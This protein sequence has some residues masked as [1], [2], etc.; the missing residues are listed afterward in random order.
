MLARAILLTVATPLLAQ[1][2]GKDSKPPT[3]PA[4]RIDDTYA[5]YSAVLANL[6]L[7]HSDHNKKYLIVDLTS[8]R[9]ENAAA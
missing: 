1:T 8:D 5:V 2:V 7:S 9:P 6:K 4:D 3:V